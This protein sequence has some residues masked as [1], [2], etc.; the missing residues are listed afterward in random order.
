MPM[1]L[2]ISNS[3]GMKRS[4]LDQDV[5]MRN[6]VLFRHYAEQCRLL[7]E[8]MPEHRSALLEM[9]RAWRALA[10]A[11]EDDPGTDRDQETQ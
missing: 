4:R 11:I 3:V 5:V 6:S 8:S 10:E 2:K 7:A 1:E 9:E